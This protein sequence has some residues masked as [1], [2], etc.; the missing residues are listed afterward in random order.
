[1]TKIVIGVSG[2]VAYP[3]DIPKGV[4]VIVR[5]FD[6]GKNATEK[7]RTLWHMK[8]DDLGDWFIEATWTFE[9]LRKFNET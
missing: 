1:M 6:D 2:G 5:D 3:I 7:E 8:V 4:T 9:D